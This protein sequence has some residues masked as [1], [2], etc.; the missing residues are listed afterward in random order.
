MT[1]SITFT[2]ESQAE[3]FKAA[4]AFLG[5]SAEKAAVEGKAE[6]SSGKGSRSRKGA[7]EKGKDEKGADEG[8][9]YTVDQ[10]RELASKI[11]SDDDQDKAIAIISDTGAESI[12]GLEKKSAAVRVKVYE[13]IKA[14]VEGAGKSRRR[15]LD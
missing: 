13:A 8:P 11:E 14:I 6:E 7:D 9:D 10:I 1:I 5:L 3:V 15:A 12:S 4:S 2:G